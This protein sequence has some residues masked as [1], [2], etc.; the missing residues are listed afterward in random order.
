VQRA[1]RALLYEG[2][3]HATAKRSARCGHGHRFGAATVALDQRCIVIVANL[4]P[5]IKEQEGQDVSDT[6]INLLTNMIGALTVARISDDKEFS[7]RIM[8][9]TRNGI[10]SLIDL[11]KAPVPAEPEPET[12]PA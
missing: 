11:T 12:A 6:A 3:T 7:D 1:S 4:A 10:A 9:I 2:A 8:E 5:F